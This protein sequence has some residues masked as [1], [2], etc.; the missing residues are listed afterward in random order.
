MGLH[1][2][3]RKCLCCKDIFLA[4]YRNGHHQRYCSKPA[5]RAAS[6]QASQLR[7]LSRQA[8]RDYFRGPEQTRRVQLWRQAHPGYARKKPAPPDGAQIALPQSDSSSSHLVTPPPVLSAPLQDVCLLNHPV[9][10]G[11]ISMFTGT[12]L[13]EDIALTARKLEARGRDI[14]GINLPEPVP[15]NYDSKTSAPP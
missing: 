14:L 12:A 9:F 15:A 3:R 7:W 1:A 8:N 4:D 5:C 11:L 13:Q 2:R 6:K 10:I